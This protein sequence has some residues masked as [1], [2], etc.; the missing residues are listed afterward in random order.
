MRKLG[1]RLH[2]KRPANLESPNCQN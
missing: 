1:Q 2:C